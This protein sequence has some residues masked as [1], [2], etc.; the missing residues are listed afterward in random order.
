MLL[1]FFHHHHHHY[2]NIAPSVHM[3]NQCFLSLWKP[4][5]SHKWTCELELKGSQCSFVKLCSEK[6]NIFSLL[7]NNRWFDWIHC[8]LEQPTVAHLSCSCFAQIAPVEN[9]NSYDEL[10]RDA[11]MCLSLMSQGLLYPQQVPLVLQV[12]KQVRGAF[13]MM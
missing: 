6:Y 9:N 3:F 13:Q 7:L 4:R 8:F 11:K 1:I 12:L 2:Y 5:S 10:K